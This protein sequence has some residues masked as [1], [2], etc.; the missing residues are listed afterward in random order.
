MNAEEI[1]KNLKADCY[2][3]WGICLAGRIGKRGRPVLATSIG[4]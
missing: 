3:Y 4:Q 2:H 1:L